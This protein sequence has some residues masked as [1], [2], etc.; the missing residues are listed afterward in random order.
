MANEILDEISVTNTYFF[1]GRTTD[2]TE[3]PKDLNTLSD[4]DNGKA[5]VLNGKEFLLTKSQKYQTI[6][7]MLA[8][9]TSYVCQVI[10]S[11]KKGFF[12]AKMICFAGQNVVLGLDGKDSIQVLFD[13]NNKITNANEIEKIEESSFLRIKGNSYFIIQTSSEEDNYEDSVKAGFSFSIITKEK[14]IDVKTVRHGEK[15]YLEVLRFYKRR[16]NNRNSNYH[17]VKGTFKITDEKTFVQKMVKDQID[18]LREKNGTYLDDWKLYT[19]ERASFVVKDAVKF[20]KYKIIEVEQTNK[21]YKIFL[22]KRIDFRTKQ[23]TVYHNR[24]PEPLFLKKENCTFDEVIE[25]SDIIK[26]R[27]R[28]LNK[29]LEKKDK[30]FNFDG[31]IIWQKEAVIEIIVEKED[32]HYSPDCMKDGYITFSITAEAIQINRQQRAS[33]RIATGKSGIPHLGLLIEDKAI[34]DSKP[35]KRKAKNLSLNTLTKVFEYAPTENQ[36]KAIKIALETPDIAL[37][38]GPPGTGKTTVIKAIVETLNEMEDKDAFCAG[39]IH[40]T[41]FQHDAVINII[42]ESSVNSLPIPKYGAKKYIGEY[43]QNL[44]N[45]KKKIIDNV[46]DKNY[47]ALNK[48]QDF[49]NY[50]DCYYEY[51][52]QPSYETEENLVNSIVNAASINGELKDK[53]IEL[54]KVGKDESLSN[55]QLNNLLLNIRGLRVFPEAFMDDG[56]ERAFGLYDA[57]DACDVL[58]LNE[59]KEKLNILQKAC[60]Y[61]QQAQVSEDDIKFYKEL[62]AVKEELL[63]RFTPKPSY[64]KYNKNTDLL[65]LC[66]EIEKCFTK[67]MTSKEKV[68]QILSDWVEYIKVTPNALDTTVKD[69]S[70]AYAST[71]QQTESRSMLNVTKDSEN[72]FDDVIIDEAARCGPPDILIPMCNATKRIILVGDHRQLPQLINEEICDELEKKGEVSNIKD[73]EKLSLFEKLFTRMKELEKQDGIKRTITLN[74]QFRTHPVLGDFASK[75]FYEEPSKGIES[76]KSALKAEIFK[77]SI[78]IFCK[79]NNKPAAA[80]WLNVSKGD[81]RSQ[82]DSYIRKSECDAIITMIKKVIESKEGKDLTYGVIGFY[83]EQVEEIKKEARKHQLNYP[84]NKLQIGTVDSFQGKQFD[85]VFLSVVRKNPR[86]IYGFITVP[87]R[88]CVSMSRQKKILVVCGDK[89]FCTTDKARIPG[90]KGIKPLADF[91]DLC[92]SNEYGLVI[93]NDSIIDEED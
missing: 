1:E 62:T 38:Q 30:I 48:K 57:I 9:N 3:M 81:E 84:E 46:Q 77:H 25:D 51:I 93:E 39:K 32:S 88:L 90:I 6:S 47:E 5:F 56:N 15:S 74:E 80:V 13:K 71:A 37:I 69:L 67:N 34:I 89:N 91:Y 86:N 23:I 7:D 29:N 63:R 2:N 8:K 26:K 87:N 52:N 27:V 59:K 36:K 22:N 41:S 54:L 55:T 4:L 42:S 12:K 24:Y 43:K 20:G 64:V 50:S 53:A 75:V 60:L 17:L 72:Y 92:S 16:N 85:V 78:P 45:W 44:E 82:N 11:D 28:Y 65:K 10:Y 49:R 35:S 33:E 76:Y 83:K 66:K 70:I 79:E 18:K 40:L 58:T 73:L 21:G 19:K 61:N 14:N 68:N 31:E